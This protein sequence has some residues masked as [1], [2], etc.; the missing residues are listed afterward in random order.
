MYG[1]QIGRS[2]YFPLRSVIADPEVSAAGNV[3]LRV[4]RELDAGGWSRSEHVVLTVEDAEGLQ[5]A[6]TDALLEAK[7][8]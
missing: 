8:R 4:G 1:L 6:L 7:A 2:K 3:I 5:E